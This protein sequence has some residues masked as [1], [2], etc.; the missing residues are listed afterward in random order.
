MKRL[1][2]TEYNWR[3]SKTMKTERGKEK[4][5]A[6]LKRV[7]ENFFFERGGT[8]LTSNM[9]P[10]SK[11]LSRPEQMFISLQHGMVSPMYFFIFSPPN[12]NISELPVLPVS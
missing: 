4:T 2:D 9:E 3:K 8:L 5:L 10:T 1:K 12:H 11:V 6:N 7:S